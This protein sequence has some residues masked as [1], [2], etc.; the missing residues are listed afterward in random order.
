MSANLQI[1][2]HILLR[3][4]LDLKFKDILLK[5]TTPSDGCNRKIKS[6]ITTD[7]KMN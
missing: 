3:K 6:H 7:V 1:P 2:K 5:F 4:T